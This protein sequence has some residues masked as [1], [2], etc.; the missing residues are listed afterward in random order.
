MGICIKRLAEAAGHPRVT[1]LLAAGAGVFGGCE[2][3]LSSAALFIT[4]RSNFRAL[5]SPG[6]ALLPHVVQNTFRDIFKKDLTHR[7]TM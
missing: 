3:T 6:E 1:S 7:Q 5:P 2:A 4:L